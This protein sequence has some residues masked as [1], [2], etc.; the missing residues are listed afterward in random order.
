[1][2]GYDGISQELTSL[3]K[4]LSGFFSKFFDNKKVLIL[5]A[6]VFLFLLIGFFG[7]RFFKTSQITKIWSWPELAAITNSSGEISNINHT[8][9]SQRFED[10][11]AEANTVFYP[12]SEKAILIFVGDVMLDRYVDEKFKRLGG[13]EL[14]HAVV[15]LTGEADA[16]IFNHEGTFPNKDIEQDL[17]SLLFSFREEPIEALKESGATIA[18]LANNHSYNFGEKIYRET[19]L[20]LRELG[21]ETFGTPVS[22]NKKSILLAKEFN[23]RPVQLYGYNALGGNIDEIVSVIEQNAKKDIPDIVFAHWGSEYQQAPSVSQ[24]AASYRFFDAGADIIIGHHP[25][26]VQPFEKIGEKLVFYSLGNFIFDQY[27]SLPAQYGLV[28]FMVVE[29]NKVSILPLP[30]SLMKSVPKIEDMSFLDNPDLYP[31][32]AGVRLIEIN[33]F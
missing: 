22:G 8:E 16:F 1:M 6:A 12:A 10:T 28:L 18:G 27:F 24:K 5:T 2:H 31:G 25:H 15:E 3:I 23:G 14:F 13:E 30:A 7:W 11:A 9:Y 29:Q 21:Y 17:A 4:R 26:V 32:F 19:V 20:N 33:E